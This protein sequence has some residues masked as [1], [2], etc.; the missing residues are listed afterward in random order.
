MRISVLNSEYIKISLKPKYTSLSPLP[1]RDAS[2]NA[3]FL[4]NEGS[5]VRHN[6]FDTWHPFFMVISKDP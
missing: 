1:P 2:T 6:Y 5:F 4:S 3:C